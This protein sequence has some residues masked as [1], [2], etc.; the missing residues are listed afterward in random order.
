MLKL[1]LVIRGMDTLTDRRS[2]FGDNID[3]LN[4][5]N[6][7]FYR[8]S[9]SH[10]GCAEHEQP[11]D[12][13]RFWRIGTNQIETNSINLNIGA[14]DNRCNRGTNYNYYCPQQFARRHAHQ[15]W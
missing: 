15:T 9:V 8:C 7:D 10:N 2:T 13:T 12:S 3:N 4:D 1:M 11:R 14:V 5:N 6:N